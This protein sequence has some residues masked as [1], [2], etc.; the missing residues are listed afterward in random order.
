MVDSPLSEGSAHGP[1]EQTRRSGDQDVTR[2]PGGA[3][4]RIPRQAHEGPLLPPATVRDSQ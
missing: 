1:P 2:A 3:A 4:A